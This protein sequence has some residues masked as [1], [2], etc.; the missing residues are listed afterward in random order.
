MERL[1]EVRMKAIGVGAA[2]PPRRS[3]ADEEEEEE[4]K[5]LFRCCSL[6]SVRARLRVWVWRGR[7]RMGACSYTRTRYADTRTCVW[8]GGCTAGMGVPVTGG[9]WIRWGRG[10]EVSVNGFRWTVGADAGAGPRRI[11]RLRCV[12]RAGD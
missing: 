6:C 5:R 12:R 7:F 4:E 11:R 3:H 8:Y 9:A 1:T 10:D 2:P